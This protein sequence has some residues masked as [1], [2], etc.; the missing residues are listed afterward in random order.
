MRFRVEYILLSALQGRSQDSLVAVVLMGWRN[1]QPSKAG[2]QLGVCGMLVCMYV[3]MYGNLCSR[4]SLQPRL[5]R[6]RYDLS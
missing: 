2:A 5:S 3:C 6:R 4:N 1:V